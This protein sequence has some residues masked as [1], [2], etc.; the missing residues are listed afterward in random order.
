[1]C[2]CIAV[3]PL[4]LIA[5]YN[6]ATSPW[7]SLYDGAMGLSPYNAS[8][9]ACTAVCEMV[10]NELESAG[11]VAAH[12]QSHS[13]H[14][15]MAGTGLFGSAELSKLVEKGVEGVAGGLSAADVIDSL[16][17][18]MTAGR[19]YC[20]VDDAMDVP[21]VEQIARRL[22]GQIDGIPTHATPMAML[23]AF[24]NTRQAKRRPVAK[25]N[26]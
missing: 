24:V 13:L 3:F 21:A 1:V 7:H 16:F 26:L 10:Y 23:G 11:E 4:P 5:S 9:M 2:V 17:A 15:S 18:Q 22:Q 8:K 14:P 6:N 25:A 12:V 19:F 20:I